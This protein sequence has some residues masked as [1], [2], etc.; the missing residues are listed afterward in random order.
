MKEFFF[1][2]A[3]NMNMPR[4]LFVPKERMKIA[5]QFPAG[6]EREQGESRRRLNKFPIQP[7]LRDLSW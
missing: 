5:R 6:C 4:H 1:S 3:Q 2:L 7:S